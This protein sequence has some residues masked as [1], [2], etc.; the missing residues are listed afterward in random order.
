MR[1]FPG[2]ELTDDKRIFNYRLSR[3]RRVVENAFGILSARWRIFRRPIETTPEHAVLICKAT[4]VLHNYLKY[5]DNNLRVAERY[6]PPL[7]TDKDLEGDEIPG[8]W[9]SETRGNLNLISIKQCGSNM[10]SENSRQIRDNLLQYF[11]SPYGS[12]FWQDKIVQQGKAPECNLMQLVSHK[13]KITKT[14]QNNKSKLDFRLFHD[15][16][17]DLSDLD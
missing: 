10:H 3:A 16:D 17:E 9:R 8:L 12:V 4:V 11:K 2:R 13:I 15:F 14:F 7:Y 6:C 1:P 5:W